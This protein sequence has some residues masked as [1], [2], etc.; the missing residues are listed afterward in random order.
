MGGAEG[1]PDTGCMCF[2][3]FNE[4]LKTEK[5]KKKQRREN[6]LG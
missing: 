1:N 4:K 5:G 2:E 3:M 6:E